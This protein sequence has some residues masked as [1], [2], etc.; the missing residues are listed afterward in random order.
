[1]G[2]RSRKAR[3]DPAAPPTPRLRGEERNAVIREGLEPLAPGERPRAVTVA[4][5]VAFVLA[6]LNLVAY[7]AGWEIDGERPKA[8]GTVMFELLMFGMAWGLWR[9]RYWAVLGFEALLGISLVIGMLSLLFASNLRA[10][11]VC[12][13]VIATSGPLFYFLIRA[14]ARIQMPAGPSR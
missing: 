11:L 10:V 2:R 9:A 8:F 7:L 4:A 5:V 1:L 12:L 6:L 3:R 14:M 13:V